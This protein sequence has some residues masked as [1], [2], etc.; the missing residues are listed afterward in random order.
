MTETN[1][2]R[3][4]ERR[5]P[6]T[7]Q[8]RFRAAGMEHAEAATIL[9]IGKTGLLLSASRALHVGAPL[10]IEVPARKRSRERRYRAEIVWSARTSSWRSLVAGAR[11]H[12]GCRFAAATGRADHAHDARDREPETPLT[13]LPGGLGTQHDYHVEDLSDRI[14]V[15]GDD[16]ANQ[17]MALIGAQPSRDSS[18]RALPSTRD[19]A[20]Q[21]ASATE[22][23]PPAG[24][25]AP[26]L[27][28]AKSVLS[29][30]LAEE[31][32]NAERAASAP[33]AAPLERRARDRRR[34]RVLWIG[35]ERR[36]EQRRHA[37]RS[38]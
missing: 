6:I 1:S 28:E 2:D 4:A 23:A 10:E 34:N 38:R 26:P 3:R 15:Q 5:I 24:R 16:W 31:P 13:V 29:N 14:D 17:A 21:R 20:L 27:H 22:A 35:P 25:P 12:Y 32:A 7:E 19:G 18:G 30:D 33:A 37:R 36:K 11:Y 8:A 9:N